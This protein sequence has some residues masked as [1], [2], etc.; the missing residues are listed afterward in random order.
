MATCSNG[1]ENPDSN[2]FCGTCGQ[3]LAKPATVDAAIDASQL[4]SAVQITLVQH[5]VARNV[6]QFGNDDFL[7]MQFA[8]ANLR[9][10]ALTGLQFSIYVLDAFGDVVFPGLWNYDEVVPA[11]GRVRTSKD[12]G[13][14]LNKYMAD[15]QRLM[16]MNLAQTTVRITPERAAFA[17]G[18]IIS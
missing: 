11:H 8:I 12:G 9:S 4:E 15:H 7:L 16:A 14:E 6:G 2:A 3:T 10:I 1:H 18:Q 17:D 13:W 5:R